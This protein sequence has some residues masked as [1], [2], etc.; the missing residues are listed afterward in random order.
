MSTPHGRCRRCGGALVPIGSARKGGKATHSDWESRTLHKQ[1]WE[2]EQREQEADPFGSPP[3][4]QRTDVPETPETLSKRDFEARAPRCQKCLSPSLVKMS[5]TAANP[6][7]FFYVCAAGSCDMTFLGW[8]ADASSSTPYR[9][10]PRR[11]AASASADNGDDDPDLAAAI[12]ESLRTANAQAEQRGSDRPFF[13][14]GMMRPPE[15]RLVDAAQEGDVDALR[16]LLMTTD[17]K[18]L[19]DVQALARGGKTPATALRYAAFH[20]HEPCVRALLAAGALPNLCNE[21]GKDALALAKLGRDHRAARGPTNERAGTITTL[22]RA[23]ASDQWEMHSISM[24][25]ELNGHI[26]SIIRLPAAGKY[27]VRDAATSKEYDLKREKVRRKLL[28]PG[29]RA[30]L[31]GL[32]TMQNNGAHV[33]IEEGLNE[34]GRYRVRLMEGRGSDYEKDHRLYVKRE[35]VMPRVL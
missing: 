14:R 35:N 13:G 8:C 33:L 2:A 12:E 25:P 7:R 32:T 30:V 21:E 28:S 18:S 24:R 11:P 1:C 9:P 27:T 15:Q 22:E 4:R 26:V 3:R 10:P 16:E 34:T 20:G 31:I 6:N 17:A 23:S 29:E 19:L 5:K